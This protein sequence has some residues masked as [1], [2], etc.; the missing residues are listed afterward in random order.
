MLILLFTIAERGEAQH[1]L[2]KAFEFGGK[3]RDKGLLKD[4][5]GLAFSENGDIFITDKG[6]DRICRFD[7]EGKLRTEFILYNESGDILENPSDIAL[8]SQGNMYV[9]TSF[10]AKVFKFDPQG[11]LL[12]S[13]GGRGAKEGEFSAIPKA[14][15]VD[16]QGNIYVIES[17]Y[18]HKFDSQGG[19]IY[20]IGGYG[21]EQGK[22][23]D[24]ASL[25]LDSQG[26]LYIA[27]QGNNRVQK[28]DSSGNFLLSFGHKGKNMG[29]FIDP[30]YI[31]LIGDTIFVVDEASYDIWKSDK[32]LRR[33]QLFNIYGEYRGKILYS[34]GEEQD[35]DEESA[36]L[37][38]KAIDNFSRIY[39]FHRYQKKFIVYNVRE[40][41]FRWSE[42]ESDYYLTLANSRGEDVYESLSDPNIIPE[43]KERWTSFDTIQNFTLNYQVDERLSFYLTDE[44]TFGNRD[45]DSHWSAEEG[46]E[47]GGKEKE[48]KN[49]LEFKVSYLYDATKE[50]ALLGTIGFSLDYLR[51]EDNPL[52]ISDLSSE[53]SRTATKK[54][55]LELIYDLS[56]YSDIT[57]KLETISTEENEKV[58]DLEGV[59]IKDKEESD[60]EQ[61]ISLTLHLSF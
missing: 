8:D 52:D 20:R 53:V 36:P 40:L 56:S 55:Y 39:L 48:T 46:F 21:G 33:I 60:L 12:F 17:D 41:S 28:F 7:R 2:D 25:I 43:D 35:E 30:K 51:D 22:F 27:D 57:L 37:R 61:T 34:R 31:H 4:P 3:E 54:A 26:S 45:D 38:F 11:E 10:S 47:W 49:D 23:D 50:L 29:E 6:R 58:Y 24:P 16:Q 59:K 32:C 44:I 9:I 1:R 18:I 15:E 5:S 14:L 13:F 42:I 19:F